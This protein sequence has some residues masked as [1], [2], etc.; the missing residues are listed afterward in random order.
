MKLRW[1]QRSCRD[2]AGIQHFISQDDPDAAGRWIVRLRDRARKAA[3]A[4]QSGRMV[5]ELGRPDVREVLL[6]GYRLVYL[7]RETD[8]VVLTVFESHRLLP[9]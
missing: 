9:I 2:L 3:Q 5:P 6:K 8:I 1:S 4:P 7:V